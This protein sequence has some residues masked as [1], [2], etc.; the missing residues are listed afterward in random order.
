MDENERPDDA[1]QRLAALMLYSG[2][3][4]FRDIARHLGLHPEQVRQWLTPK[5][6]RRTECVATSRNPPG[7]R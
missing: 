2:G 5:T 4:S 1:D 3:L 7:T 6:D